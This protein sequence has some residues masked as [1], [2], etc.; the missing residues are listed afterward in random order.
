MMNIYKSEVLGKSGISAKV[1]ADS[2]SKS[3]KRIST[4]EL[5]YPRFIHSEFMTH[6]LFSRNA[7][8]SR[9][10]PV[11]TMLKQVREEAAK[12]IHWGKNQSGMQAREE[13][14]DGSLYW[15][16][17]AESAARHAEIMKEKQYHKQITNRLIEPFQ[18]IKVVVTSTEWEN[19]FNLRI[20]PDAQP[21]IQ[22]LAKC[23]KSAMT[24]STPM[25]LSE[26]EWHLPYVNDPTKTIQNGYNLEEAIKASVARCARVSYMKHDNSNPSI[27]DDLELYNV[28]ATRPYTDKR[29]HE[30]AENDP[31]HLSP[32]EHQ[33]TPMIGNGKIVSL[34]GPEHY[35]NTPG[36]THFDK[37]GQFWSGNFAGWIQY[38]QII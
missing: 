21:E 33:A 35:L 6:R 19:F 36:I 4:L 27:E 23:M 28:L 3:G 24:L 37:F 12:P 25:F 31:V 15:N 2:I 7:S 26:H 22:E 34:G 20:H 13:L 17:A 9:A 38:R 16:D 30:F 1:V 29:G 14:D 32:L 5:R 18:F 10:I 8:S 11:E